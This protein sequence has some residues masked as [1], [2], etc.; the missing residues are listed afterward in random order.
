[1]TIRVIT[2]LEELFADARVADKISRNAYSAMPHTIKDLLK[3][4]GFAARIL[5][6]GAY[7]DKPLCLFYEIIESEYEEDRRTLAK[8]PHI[9][10]TKGYSSLC[11]EGE[12]SNSHLC[13][14]LPIHPDSFTKAK[15]K[16]W[17]VSLEEIN[18]WVQS[19]ILL[20]PGDGT[21]D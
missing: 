16:S 5:I 12:F 15:D 1:M 11:V 21:A 19:R 6:D 4:G 9:S 7:S 2:D 8:T 18:S 3:P 14:L 13:G 10:L 17:D 20:D